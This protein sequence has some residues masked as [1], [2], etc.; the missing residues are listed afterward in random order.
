MPLT[1]AELDVTDVRAVEA[2]VRELRPDI[3]FNCAVIEVD[4]CERN[5]DAARR[6]NVE[7]PGHLAEA[8]HAAGAVLVHFSTNYVFGGDRS[9]D[10]PYTTE[11]FPDPVNVYGV[12]K[13]AGEQETARRCPRSFVVRTSWV[14]GPGKSSFLSTVA[15][16]L[17]RGQRVQAI[18][19]TF[20]NS[21]YVEDLVVRVLDIVERG[22]F[23]TYQVVN[24]GVCSYEIFA[25]EAARLTGSDESLI[26]AV[27]EAD[28]KR[29]AR[30]PRSTP[31][32]CLLSEKSGFAPMRRWQDALAEWIDQSTV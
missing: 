27:S 8:A 13:W 30:R 10:H 1:H 23:G 9:D 18:C 32:R 28:M 31:M 22:P 26:D 11:D 6:V 17:A 24:A 2:A 29:L 25:R 16:R 3:L 21:T 14:Y 5:P 15:T 4:A 7:G 19:D 20:A 12:T